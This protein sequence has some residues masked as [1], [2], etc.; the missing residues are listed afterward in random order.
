MGHTTITFYDDDR[1]RDVPAEVYYPADVSGDDVSVAVGEFP[2]LIFGH[3][4]VISY[5]AYENFWTALVPEGYIMLF[6]TTESGFSPNH[7]TFGQDLSF[8]N[9]V[10]QDENSNA[11]SIFYQ[12][13]LEASAVMG[14]SM[15]GGSAFLAAGLNSNINT[16]ITYAAA[17]TNPSAIVAAEEISVPGL[18]F[19][20]LEDGVAPPDENQVPMYN[21]LSSSCKTYIGVVD[22]VHCNFGGWSFYCSL[23]DSSTDLPMEEQQEISLFYTLNWL[24]F[25]LKNNDTSNDLFED[26][27]QTSQRIIFEKYCPSNKEENVGDKSIQVLPN[28][29][30]DYIFIEAINET[31]FE[32]KIL[33]INGKVLVQQNLYNQPAKIST[34]H[35]EKGLYIVEIKNSRGILTRKM[36][37]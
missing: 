5:T 22:G 23:V 12:R 21:A 1:G 4:F 33:D 9:E 27:L 7:E 13:V 10:M 32:F 37:K 11:S 30:N 36:V 15:G 25:Y 29:F 2:V 31:L 24:N 6:P 34:N 3:G 35:L 18:V 16:I 26:S 14:H 19:S 28:P 17:E 20:G 8:L